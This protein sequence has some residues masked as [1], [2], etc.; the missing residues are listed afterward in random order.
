MSGVRRTGIMMSLLASSLWLAV[1]RPSAPAREATPVPASTPAAAPDRQGLPPGHP[2]VE[3]AAAPASGG[4]GELTWTTPE[5]WK[6][7]A[8]SSSM[9]RAQY[10]VPGA[11]GAAECVVFYFGPGQGGDAASNADRW[12]SQF[13]KPD[14]TAAS[15]KTSPL[16]GGSVKVLLVE[17]A[18]TFRA[19]SMGGGPAPSSRPGFMLLGAIAEGPDANWFF[20]LTGPERTVQAQRAALLGMLQS[21][22]TGS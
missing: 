12:A 14:G 19:G 18:G 6:E 17:V 20:K 10:E 13:T 15:A 1:C 11:A 7:Q 2:P 3:G 4:G 21:L 16:Q 5:G 8:P 9:R 22:K